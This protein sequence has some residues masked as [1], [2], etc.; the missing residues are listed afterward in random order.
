MMT[1]PNAR[2]DWCFRPKAAIATLWSLF[3]A[4]SKQVYFG[5]FPAWLDLRGRKMYFK[6]C[7]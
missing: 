5:I 3:F 7:F 1:D 2:L 6:K 4:I